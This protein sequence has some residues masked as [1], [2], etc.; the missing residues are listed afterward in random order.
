MVETFTAPWVIELHG[1]QMPKPV[2]LRVDSELIV[3][4]VVQGDPNAPDVDLAPYGAEALGVSRQHVTIMTEGERL[5]I[6]DLNSNNG[7]FLN[8]NRLKPDEGYF[9]K[10]GDQI[11]LGRMHIDLRVTISPAYSGS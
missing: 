5:M 2:R 8:G 4:C 3:G 7:T 1:T 9:I 10:N 11:Q 6:R